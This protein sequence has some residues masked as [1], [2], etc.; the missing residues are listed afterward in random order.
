P[1]GARSTLRSALPIA[2]VKRGGVH[3]TFGDPVAG[4]RAKSKRAPLPRALAKRQGGVLLAADAIDDQRSALADVSGS[5]AGFKT[6]NS[7]EWND[8]E[9]PNDR[10]AA[11]DGSGMFTCCCG[12]ASQLVVKEFPR[13]DGDCL[14]VFDDRA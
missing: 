10:Q 7:A 11:I 6:E 9:C 13:R 14:I 8:V 3:W 2:K 5:P 12:D 1:W 4:K